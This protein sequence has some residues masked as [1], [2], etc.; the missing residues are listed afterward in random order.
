MAPDALSAPPRG[1]WFA[2]APTAIEDEANADTAADG[3]WPRIEA[4]A[5]PHTATSY[6]ATRFTLSHTATVPQIR[7]NCRVQARTHPPTAGA[8]ARSQRA[9]LNKFEIYSPSRPAPRSRPPYFGVCCWTTNAT[10]A[11]SYCSI[12]WS[13]VM[14]TL[15][16]ST[17]SRKGPGGSDASHVATSGVLKDGASNGPSE[18]GTAPRPAV[19]PTP[20]GDVGADAACGWLCVAACL[21][22][23]SGD[24]EGGC[25]RVAWAGVTPGNSPATVC[26]VTRACR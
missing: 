7:P 5:R 10:S 21:L 22:W 13:S 8:L 6:Y 18:A 3:A 11:R 15:S 1:P 25:G 17:A 24:G 12:C 4:P 23:G 9:T 26:G 20:A 2:A 19:A 16:A 14:V